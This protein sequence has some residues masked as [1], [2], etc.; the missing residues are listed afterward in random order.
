MTERYNK[1][2]KDEMEESRQGATT[3]IHDLYSET[4]HLRTKFVEAVEAERLAVQNA[5]RTHREFQLAMRGAVAN[6]LN[7]P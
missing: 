2:L 7:Q 5:L 1:V 6:V 4:K 3:I